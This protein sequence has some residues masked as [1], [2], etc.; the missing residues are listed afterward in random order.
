MATYWENSCS[1]GLRCVSWYKYL[2]VSLVFSHL[3]FWSGNLFLIAPFPDLCLLVPLDMQTPVKK[4]FQMIVLKSL[5]SLDK[6][7]NLKFTVNSVGN[8]FHVP[9]IHI[10]MIYI[11]FTLFH[12]ETLCDRQISNGNLSD[13][14]GIHVGDSCDA[15]TCDYGYNE[16]EGV[17]S[18]N[19]TEDG[20][21]DFNGSSVCVGRYCNLTLASVVRVT[22]K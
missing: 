13:T 22:R 20:S 3:G 8:M 5:N 15:F 11:L 12:V 4:L 16:T 19:C 10:T 1:F 7:A 18:F 17:L 2:T 14:C 21:W 9:V 6:N